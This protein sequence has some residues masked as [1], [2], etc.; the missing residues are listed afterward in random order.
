MNEIIRKR[1]SVR[2][3]DVMP[4]DAEILENIRAQILKVKP[5]YP[6]IKYSIEITSKTKGILGV[7]APHF[8]IFGSEEKEGAA[9][10]I[11]FIGQQLDLYFS[12]SGIGTC[13][14][15][16]S[17]PGEKIESTLPHVIAMAFGKPA[18]PLHRDISGFKRK[19]ISEISRGDD[20]RI[21][22]ARLA[23]S[24]VNM[25]NW[26]F[27]AENGKIHCYCKKLNPLLG[28]MF[29]EMVRIDMGIALCHIAEESDN[30][31]F[32]KELTVPHCKGYV[33]MGTVG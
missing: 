15:G 18:E 33:Y 4:L 30:F 24:A 16:A 14:L 22:A 6:E 27:V 7:K 20:K 23:P 26:Y 28:F 9:E 12:A 19:S 13:W 1:K 8:L 25:Q 2:K 17:K 10:N 3:Y 21:E 32:S 5:L 11:G 29:N 31:Q